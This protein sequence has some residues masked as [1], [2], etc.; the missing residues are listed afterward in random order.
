MKTRKY[1]WILILLGWLLTACQGEGRYQATLITEGEHA[2]SGTTYGDLVM[3]GGETT[4]EE[5]AILA[6]SAHLLAG[7]LILDGTIQGNLSYLNGELSLGP[8]ARIEGDLNLAGAEG[9]RLDPETVGGAIHTG[10]GIEVPSSPQFGQEPGWIALRWLISSLVLGIAALVLERYLPRQM[11]NMGEAALEH[12]PVAL[13]MGLLA[14]IVGLTLLVLMAYTIVLLPV[15]FLVLGLLSLAVVYGWIAWGRVLG[16][17]AA[18]KMD[19]QIASRWEAFAGTV[20]FFILLNGVNILPRLGG[21]IS[22]LAAA[23]GLGAVYLTRFGSRR[24][25]PASWQVEDQ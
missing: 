22:L 18:S 10:I 11:K 5:D 3:L 7:N 4:L 20:I 19:L 13:A 25:V 1:L 8:A 2:L 12:L 16:S 17:W 15:A 9:S 24:F 23:A 21:L 6:G 14:G